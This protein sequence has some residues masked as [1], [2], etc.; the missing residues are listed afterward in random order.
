MDDKERKYLRKVIETLEED[1]RITNECYVRTYYELE[2]L[3]RRYESLLRRL[4]EAGK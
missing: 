4:E 2:G 1:L 3:K